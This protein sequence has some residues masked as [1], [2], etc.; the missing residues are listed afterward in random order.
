[1]RRGKKADYS[2]ILILCVFILDLFV[3]PSDPVRGGQKSF[4]LI[5]DLTIGQDGG[6]ENLLF[7]GVYAVGLDRDQN[8]YILDWW[9]SS[10]PRIQVFNSQGG[11]LRSIPIRKGQGPGEA[12]DV[13]ELAVGP[14]GT[15][16][17][18]DW[19]QNKIMLFDAKGMFL[20]Q[21]KPEVQP[22]DFALLPG[23]QVILLG[24]S[25]EKLLH[26]CDKDGK[27]LASYG[28]PFELPAKL[29]QYKNM[30]FLRCPNR[31]N[32]GPDG[33]VYVLDP[34]RFEISIYRQ[35]KL[36][37]KVEGRS[38][39]FS[40]TEVVTG[41]GGMGIGYPRVTM[42]P[43]GNRLYVGVVRMARAKKGPNE[44]IIYEKG[45][46][47]GAVTLAGWLKAIDAQG[48][49]YFSE[50]TDFPK[51]VRYVIREK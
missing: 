27:I 42:L 1:M 22:R 23:E 10:P 7:S 51:M 5:P 9:F 32:V 2:R 3:S 13:G 46:R 47:V 16:Y 50:D 12:T 39:A 14:S 17:V 4:L 19:G 29:S 25:R 34:H 18:L 26:V 15:I 37:G 41:G 44:L 36:E 33:R 43:F 45:E 31:F 28:E 24:A 21:F 20:R 6:D 40:P 11:F 8:I 35:E 48:R 49:L 30:P 38:D